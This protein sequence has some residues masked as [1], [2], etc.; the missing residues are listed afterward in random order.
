MG[1]AFDPSRNSANMLQT[2]SSYPSPATSLWTSKPQTPQLRVSTSKTLYPIWAHLVSSKSPAQTSQKTT[3]T[4]PDSSLTASRPPQGRRSAQTVER[5]LWRV[6]ERSRRGDP[7]GGDSGGEGAEV[8]RRV[9]LQSASGGFAGPRG[10][11]TSKSTR[12]SN[13]MN[14]NIEFGRA[15]AEAGGGSSRLKCSYSIAMSLSQSEGKGWEPC[16]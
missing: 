15:P 7:G 10:Q 3:P 5:R 13:R 6:A 9:H 4:H 14:S 8:A 11:R 1:A 2:T 12:A 16:L